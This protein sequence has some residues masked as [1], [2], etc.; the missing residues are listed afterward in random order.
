MPPKDELSEELN[1]M[2]DTEIDFSG[3]KKED[4]ELFHELVDEGLLLEPMVKHQAKERSK[5]SIDE[6]ID[7]YQFGQLLRKVM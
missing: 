3:L 6:F 1:E 7:D 2:L 4:L 5:E